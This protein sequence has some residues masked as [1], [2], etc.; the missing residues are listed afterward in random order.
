MHR[1]GFSTKNIEYFERDFL[2]ETEGRID[3]SSLSINALENLKIFHISG[4]PKFWEPQNIIFLYQVMENTVAGFYEGNIPLIFSAF[5]G[6]S[7]LEIIIGT[8]GFDKSISESNS[9]ILHSTLIS[10]L[11]GLDIKPITENKIKNNLSKQ[12]YTGL[13]TGTPSDILENKGKTLDYD[14]LMRG[15]SDKTSGISI[16]AYP[17]KNTDITNLFSMVLN[18]IRIILESERHSGQENPTVRQYKARLEKYLEKLQASK[19]QGLW[20]TTV[21]LH[22]KTQGTLNQI[23]A[24]TKSAFSGRNSIPDQIRTHQLSYRPNRIGSIINP[25][26]PSP[27]QFKWPYM[28]SS[29]HSSGDLARLVKLPSNEIPGFKIKPYVKFNL[30]PDT[31]EGIEI[32]EIIDQAKKIGHNYKVPVKGLKKHGLIVGGTGSGKTNTLFYILRALLERDI[33]FLVLEPAKTEYRKLL[34][35]E[36][37][38]EKLQIFTLG[39]NTVSPFRLNPFKVHEGMSVQTH[40]DLLKSV[41]N[42]SFYMWGP[43]PHVLEQCLYEVYQD[44]GWDFTTNKNS[45]GVTQNA[46]PTLTDLY[47]KVDE[48][49]N[50]LGYSP[51]T[52]MELKS[53][54]KTRLNSLRIGGKGLMLDTKSS[55][56][57]K[58]LI[59]RPTVLEL[60]SLGDD[61]EKSFLMGLVL[62]MLYEYYV[63]QGLKEEKV[64]S[65]ITVIEEAHRLL[66]KTSTSNAFTGDMRGKAVET[67]TNILSEIRAYG[68]GFLIAEQIPT[69]LSSDVIK[70]TNLKV[71]HRIVADDDRQVMAASMNIKETDSSIVSTMSVGEAVVFSEGDDGAYNVKVPY[72]KLGEIE[73][74][75]EDSMIVKVMQSFLN[76]P[77]YL[78]P[79]ISC[80][81]FCNN[82]CKYK[83]QGAKILDIKRYE[84][85]YPKLLLSLLEQNQFMENLEQMFE[86]GNDTARRCNDLYGVKLCASIQG[87]EKYF[88]DLGR[89]YHWSYHNQEQLVD[90]FQEIYSESLEHYIKKGTIILRE[91]KV[92]QFKDTYTKLVTNLQPT[93]FCPKICKDNKCRYRF[94]VNDILTD[95]EN[96]ETFVTII[97]T[98]TPEM[99]LQLYIH[100]RNVAAQLN[101]SLKNETSTKISLCYALQK[102]YQFEEF[103]HLHIATVVNNLLEQGKDNYS[104]MGE[105]Q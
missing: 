74:L 77:E 28:Y 42:A 83:D 89:L 51:E 11:Y 59:A 73:G 44:K 43:L 46:F 45:R 82:I 40:L 54:L 17:M 6:E 105:M 48:V 39:D 27:G 24:I 64:L 57:F 72:A 94:L 63:S 62:T 84:N 23:K 80:S 101:P 16:I 78:S 85:T 92:N 55:M 30:A 2:D 66:G 52:N 25:A 34:F 19:S 103:S 35:D 53:S 13:L 37:F 67:F 90:H 41:F 9:N 8:W 102:T 71:M 87:S 69:K 76:D 36:G 61:E 15:I 29:I 75:N 33:P 32:G 91:E 104:V 12:P 38:R 88:D 10:S 21:Y 3:T 7:G 22:A 60:E 1:Q 58:Q 86:A 68:E 98:G 49:V 56:S 96:N 81:K 100:C 97:N 14:A 18:E 93:A 26:P 31:R 4:I 79:Y 70:N 65:H 99:W 50:K 95:E 5:G 20:S 47:N